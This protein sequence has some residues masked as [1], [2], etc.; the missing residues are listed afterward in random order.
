[1]RFVTCDAAEYGELSQLTFSAVSVNENQ[2]KDEISDVRHSGVLTV[3]AIG[4]WS[5]KC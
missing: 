1:M 4:V 2:V 3:I 5:G